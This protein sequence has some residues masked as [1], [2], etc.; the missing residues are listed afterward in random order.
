MAY[1]KSLHLALEVY[2]FITY[3]LHPVSFHEGFEAA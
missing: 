3:Y 2:L 1:L